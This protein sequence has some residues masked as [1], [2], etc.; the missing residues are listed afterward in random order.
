MKGECEGL[1][2]RAVGIILQVKEEGRGRGR[3][4]EGR[5]WEEKG[6]GREEEGRAGR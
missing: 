1:G 4:E 5:D 3:E 6:R 2:A